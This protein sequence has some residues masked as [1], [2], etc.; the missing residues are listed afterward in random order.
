MLTEI[1]AFQRQLTFPAPD[2]A[3]GPVG[4]AAHRLWDWAAGKLAALHCAVRELGAIGAFR[5][6]SYSN[7]KKPLAIAPV[8]PKPQPRLSRLL[9]FLGVSNVVMAAALFAAYLNIRRLSAKVKHNVK[10]LL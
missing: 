9:V 4:I 6:G 3:L 10:E 5:R 1:R 2:Y 8:S 7:A